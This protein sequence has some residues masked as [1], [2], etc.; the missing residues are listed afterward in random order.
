MER[1]ILFFAALFLF[2]HLSFL[3][4]Q[5]RPE[6]LTIQVADVGVMGDA[7]FYVGLEKGFFKERGIEL[8]LNRFRSGG[9]MM[10]PLGAGKLDV[11]RG[12]V[13]IALFNSFARGWPVRV[14]AAGSVDWPGFSPDTFVVRPDLKGLITRPRD[15]KGRKVA[16]NAPASALVYVLGKSLELDGLTMKDVDM[17]TIP[18]RDMGVALTN[19]AI[20]AALAAEPFVTLYEARGQAVIWKRAPDFVKDPYMQVSVLFFNQDWASKNPQGAK[21][22]MAAYLKAIRYYYEV[23]TKG[24]NRSEV[25]DIM[26][27]Y[28]ALKERALYDKIQWSIIDPNGKVLEE[29]LKDQQDWYFK[30]GMVTQKVDV[31][32]IVDY[33][34]LKYALEQL[35]AVR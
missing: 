10:A 32:Q 34:Y 31:S 15:L 21:E 24:V 33:A 5:Q 6:R 9:D 13:N 4:A 35:G 23:A 25:V 19:R 11:G 26:I 7:P 18:F 27:K 2:A 29:S 20:D 8:A 17:V 1:K 30:Q 14:V 22:F 12:G 3:N 16:V 28:T